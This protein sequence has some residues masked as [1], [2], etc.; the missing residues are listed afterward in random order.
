MY[1]Y[2]ANRS[3]DIMELEIMPDH[4]HILME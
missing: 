3:V 2:A 4:M 1:E